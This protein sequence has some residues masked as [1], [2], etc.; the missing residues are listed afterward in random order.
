VCVVWCVWG[1]VWGGMCVWCVWG[2]W[3][4]CVCVLCV[5]CV[6]RVVAVYFCKPK[7]NV[8][9]FHISHSALLAHL[10]A[11]PMTVPCAPGSG[12]DTQLSLVICAHPPLV[13]LPDQVTKS[14]LMTPVL[15]PRAQIHSPMR[16]LT[17]AQLPHWQEA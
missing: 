1:C 10:C 13:P 15:S 9:G 12:Q 3:R 7:N 4:V 16:R 17:S 11:Y 2:V 5:V 8:P 6:C 14:F